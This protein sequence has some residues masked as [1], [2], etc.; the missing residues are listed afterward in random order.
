MSETYVYRVR[1]SKGKLATGFLEAGSKTA[2]ANQLRDNGY[3]IIDIY[4]A[5]LPGRKLKFWKSRVSTLDLALYCRQLAVM[6]S[7]GVPILSCLMVLQSQTTNK[8]LAG[9]SSALMRLL[10]EGRTLTNAVQQFP[11]VLPGIFAGMIKAGEKS[12]SLDQSLE[13]LALHF[14]KEHQI[15]EKIKVAISYPLIVTAVSILTIL[16]FLTFV[17]P[18][19]NQM[20]LQSD[21]SLPLTTQIVV[22]TS[23]FFSAHW[24]L[25]LLVFITGYFILNRLACTR[26]GKEIMDRILIKTPVVGNVIIKITVF[27]FCITLSTLVRN[28]IPIIQSM[29]IVK[30]VIANSYVSAMIEKV[31]NY[32]SAGKSI[33]ESLID[34]KIFPP[35]FIQMVKVGESTGKLDVLL[36]QVAS[37]YDRDVEY[38][39]NR[40]VKL[41]EPVLILLVGGIVG[42][43]VSAVFL[44]VIKTIGTVY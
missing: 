2:A 31:K 24:H 22:K 3:Y 28:G 8:K 35:M 23:D 21:V 12:G 26:R 18:K 41:I 1:D 4:P 44:P 14:E 37:Y 29:D 39:L 20:L 36:D 27:R 42:I 16:V 5:T 30:G 33:T 43:I 11:D 25:V 7:A 9:V 10:E 32:V 6:V 38:N 34:S 13:R 19:V 40:L 17:L 15:K